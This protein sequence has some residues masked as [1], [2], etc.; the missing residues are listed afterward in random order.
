MGCS[1]LSDLEYQDYLISEQL[2][3]LQNRL[4]YVGRHILLTPSLIWITMS[5]SYLAIL[6]AQT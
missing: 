2:C 4:A 6:M 3:V 5:T 1:K